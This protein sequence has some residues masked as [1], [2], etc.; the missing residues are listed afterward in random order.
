[1]PIVDLGIRTFYFQYIK[2][3]LKKKIYDKN[4]LS[5]TL[6]KDELQKK[7]LNYFSNE[8]KEKFKISNTVFTKGKRQLDI[9]QT[10]SK[11]KLRDN[12]TINIV[13][14]GKELNFVPICSNSNNMLLSV[15]HLNNIPEGYQRYRKIWIEVNDN[16]LLQD[17]TD[18]IFKLL[19]I[20]EVNK[21]DLKSVKNHD[22][23]DPKK[24]FQENNLINND[25]I[26]VWKKN[27]IHCRIKEI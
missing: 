1:M 6:M 24:S 3:N 16:N 15:S 13:D 21:Y 20:K 12:D 26:Y 17:F 18:Q 7:K 9:N 4:T 8:I 25:E 23:L 5:I 11:N 14:I 2:I 19:E 10:F 27:Y 22:I